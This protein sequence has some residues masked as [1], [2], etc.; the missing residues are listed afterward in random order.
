V[1][2]PDGEPLHERGVAVSEP[3]LYFVG[4]RYLYALTSD[5]VNGVGRD[6]ERIVRAIR[7]RTRASGVA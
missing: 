7:A 3:G 2:G 4:L 6:A 1:F 5:T